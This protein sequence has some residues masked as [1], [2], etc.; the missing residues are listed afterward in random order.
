MS[1]RIY[2][3]VLTGN[4]QYYSD[5][6]ALPWQDVGPFCIDQGGH[7][8]SVHSDAKLEF[9]IDFVLTQEDDPRVLIG[10]NNLE[11]EVGLTF[12]TWWS[13]SIR[14]CRRP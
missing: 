4:L 1:I 2:L 5:P 7:L 14:L 8:V 9:L 3:P 10:M 12:Q 6:A 11:V 13:V